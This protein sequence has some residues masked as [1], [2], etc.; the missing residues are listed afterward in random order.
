MTVVLRPQ[1]QCIYH[2]CKA[3]LLLFTISLQHPN[4]IPETATLPATQSLRLLQSLHCSHKLH[5]YFPINFG[6]LFSANARRPSFLSSEVSRGLY[7]SRSIRRPS[8]IGVPGAALIAFLA[9]R[10]ESGAEVSMDEDKSSAASSA[11]L[12]PWA[13]MS[14]KPSIS[15]INFCTHQY[16]LLPPHRL[17][18]P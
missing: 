16:E 6:F 9:A 18:D 3:A 14:S 4:G 11:D 13:I 1:F 12:S 15:C 5:A 10:R 7:A 2:C 8:L 17:Y